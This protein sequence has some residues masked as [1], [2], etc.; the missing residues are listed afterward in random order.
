MFKKCTLLVAVFTITACASHAPKQTWIVV[1]DTDQFTDKTTCTVTTGTFYA[2]D[3]V[4]TLDGNY[5][6][7]IQKD[8]SNII[9][10]V[11]SGG[12]IKIPVGN[13]QLRVDANPVWT[14]TTDET[15]L[16]ESSAGVY[17]QPPVYAENLSDEQKKA[18]AETYKAAMNSTTKI[19]S[20]FTSTT[21]DKA[22]T[23][24]A[25]MLRG[26]KLIYR[27]VG[28]NQAASSTGEVL[29]DNSLKASLSQCGIA[30]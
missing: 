26:Q 23:I 21:G 27:T 25:E 9:I 2:G 10:G 1:T 4:Y 22:K 15:M 18:F 12:K 11:K 30:L 20:P 6:P 13:I 14:I 5:Y 28:L 8:D 17:A 19:M 16:L 29:L 3:I 24:L 7:Y